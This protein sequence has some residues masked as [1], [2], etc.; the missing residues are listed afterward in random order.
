MLPVAVLENSTASLLVE[1]AIQPVN[2]QDG[3]VLVV[4]TD[5]LAAQLF[6]TPLAAA[7]TAD[8]AEPGSQAA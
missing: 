2:A 7:V 1:L 4:A 3:L 5:R 6:G 8:K